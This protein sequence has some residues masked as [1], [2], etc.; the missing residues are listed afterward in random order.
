MLQFRILLSEEA[1]VMARIL[2]LQEE[3]SPFSALRN[4]LERDHKVIIVSTVEKAMEMLNSQCIDLIISKVHLA[5][6][7]MFD[8]LNRVKHD[9]HL[10]DIPF[11]C[12]CGKLSQQASMLDPTLAKV[13]LMIGAEKYISLQ[14][15]CSH[16]SCDF[17][18]LKRAIEGCLQEKRAGATGGGVVKPHATS[19]FS[20]PPAN[21]GTTSKHHETYRHN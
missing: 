7:S 6:G 18:A 4:S 8:F 2:I 14:Q 1:L 13:G 21:N 10:R 11:I 9:E 20:E 3:P 12:F 5:K 16:D 17:E 19:P 15:Y